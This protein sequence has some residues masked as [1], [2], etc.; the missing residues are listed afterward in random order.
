MCFFSEF[1]AGRNKVGALAVRVALRFLKDFRLPKLIIEVID[2]LSTCRPN[3]SY[4]SDILE[5]CC[6]I[7][8][9]FDEVTF[10]HE[11]PDG[12]RV[13]HGLA[14]LAQSLKFHIPIF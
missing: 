3:N 5:D 12:N 14:T 8:R 7:C 11:D 10:N 4:L 1:K 9:D 6:M 13:V 2:R